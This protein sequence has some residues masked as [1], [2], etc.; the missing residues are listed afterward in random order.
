APF[1]RR[2]PGEF[3]VIVDDFERVLA[4]ST[5]VERGL[6]PVLGI[7][8]KAAEKHG[9]TML[10]R[11]QSIRKNQYSVPRTRAEGPKSHGGSWCQCTRA[12]P[13]LRSRSN[14][15]AEGRPLPVSW[16]L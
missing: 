15:R 9:G 7:A 12:G 5:G 4:L 13:S 16:V 8:G 3:G 11:L 1:E 10:G 14:K 6:I 2:G